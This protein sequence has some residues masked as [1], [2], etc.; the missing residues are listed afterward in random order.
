ME[1]FWLFKPGNIHQIR[2]G[3]LDGPCMTYQG[4]LGPKLPISSLPWG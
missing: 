4:H 3:L 2:V 1:P